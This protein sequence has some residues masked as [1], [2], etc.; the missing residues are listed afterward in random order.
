MEFE[1]DSMKLPRIEIFLILRDK[2]LGTP[3]GNGNKD[4]VQ[5][6][7]HKHSLTG[8]RC[9]YTVQLFSMIEPNILYLLNWKFFLSS[10]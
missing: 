8:F 3:I 2:I 10:Q 9:G 1:K 4:I 7:I 6:I 5:Y